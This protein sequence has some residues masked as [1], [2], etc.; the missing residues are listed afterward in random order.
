MSLLTVRDLVMT[1]KSGGTEKTILDH[2]ALDLN[3]G[4]IT[5]VAGASG[6]GKTMTGMAV[7]GLAPRNTSIS[8]S[9]KYQGQ[10]LV[11]LPPKAHNALRGAELA[12]VFQDASSSLH[13]M[14]SIERQMTD[15][16]RHHE[17]L[18]KREARKRALELLNRTRV[19]NPEEA[20]R[21]YP[22]QFSGGQLQRIGIASA[23]MCSPRVVIADEPTTALDVTVQAGILRL[24]RELCDEFGLGVMLVTHDFGVLSSIADEIVVMDKGVVVETG[25]RHDVIVEPKHPYTRSLIESLPTAETERT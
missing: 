21:K 10:E 1:A 25:D 18:S 5:G 15:H 24:L 17:K 12:M 7:M 23:L 22:H 13:P 6:S 11:G 8:G 14:L 2:V 16:A 4:T 9:I 19:P 20:L 3:E